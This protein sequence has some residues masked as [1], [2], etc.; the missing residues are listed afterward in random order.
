MSEFLKKPEIYFFFKMFR[1]DLG[2]PPIFLVSGN[3]N[4]LAA[5]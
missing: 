1:P 5:G 3:L 4:T 2:V